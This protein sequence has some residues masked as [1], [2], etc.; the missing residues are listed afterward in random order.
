VTAAEPTGIQVAVFDID[1]T[2]LDSATGILAGFGRALAAGGVPVPDE[3]S[4]R[5]HLGPPLRDFLALSG[6]TADRIDEAAQAYHDYYLTEGL[7]RATAYPGIEVLLRRLRAA[8]LR[9][10]TASAKRTTTAQA[11]ITEH[12]LAPY[13]EVIAGTDEQRLTKAETLSGV[14][15]DLAADPARTIMVGDRQH[16]IVGAHACDVRAVGARWGYGVDDE[17]A[18]AGADW[19]ADD[20]ATVGRLLGV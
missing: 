18:R 9:L 20:P 1:G 13:F 2:L 17:L 6:V 15:T 8:G 10:A 3:A 14:L 12:G 11:I 7:Q 5:V 4:L 16:D 19:L